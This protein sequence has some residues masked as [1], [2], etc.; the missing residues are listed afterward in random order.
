MLC[1]CLE[2]I[3]NISRGWVQALESA[4]LPIT[5]EDMEGLNR[6]RCG[7]LIGTAFGGLMTYQEAC[8]VVAKDVSPSIPLLPLFA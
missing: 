7:V 5:T 2:G 8:E 4:G 6:L 1:W 3:C